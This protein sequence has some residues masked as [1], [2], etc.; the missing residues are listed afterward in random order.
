L[1]FSVEARAG[2]LHARL[3]GRESAADMR[4]FLLAVHAACARHGIPR[5]LMS[6]LGSRAVFRAEDYGLP[7]YANR[8][9]TPACRI[10]LFGDTPE[11]NSAHEYIEVVA[12]QQSLEVRA[13]RDEAAAVRW[14][15]AAPEPNRRYR[16]A[17]LVL[18]GAPREPGV[19]ALWEEDEL[20]YY[21]R[22]ASLRDR[23]LEHLER[24]PHATHYSW[25][26]CLDP[27]ARE[28][29]LLREFERMFGRLPRGNRAR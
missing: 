1:R 3:S 2:Y 29:E 5:V 6:I 24:G 16:L 23:L 18:Q 13:F 22:A 17:R 4:E 10:A 14:L 21:G 11:L 20:I 7:G 27:A 12:R 19:Y 28:A 9:A 8:L 15:L 25:E 26:L